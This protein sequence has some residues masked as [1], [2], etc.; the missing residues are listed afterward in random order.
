MGGGCVL[1]ELFR[2][3]NLFCPSYG[4]VARSAG[5]VLQ[6][7]YR[8]PQLRSTGSNTPPLR[9]HPFFRKR[10]WGNKV[11]ALRAAFIKIAPQSGANL[12]NTTL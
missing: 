12:F 4:G 2:Y 10:G 6:S 9:R 3:R 11:A 8:N 7:D 1:L 5:V